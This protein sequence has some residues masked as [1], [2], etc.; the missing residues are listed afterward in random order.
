[1]D[2]FLIA[3]IG[4]GESKSILNTMVKGFSND[5]DDDDDDDDA[6]HYHLYHHES[7]L[8]CRR[9]ILAPLDLAIYKR[10]STPLVDIQPGRFTYAEQTT[11]NHVVV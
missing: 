9:L 10:L 4:G 11:E 8:H 3:N 1:L 5:D 2:T 7:Q 6:L